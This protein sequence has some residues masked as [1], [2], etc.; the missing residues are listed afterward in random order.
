MKCDQKYS[1]I[2]EIFC[3]KDKLFYRVTEIFLVMEVFLQK[4]NTESVALALS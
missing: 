4:E 1:D 3:D 2:S